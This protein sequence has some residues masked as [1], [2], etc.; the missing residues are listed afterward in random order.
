MQIKQ[1]IK[2]KII[3][4]NYTGLIHDFTHVHSNSDLKNLNFLS[5]EN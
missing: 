5:V 3:H 2:I 1:A 4:L